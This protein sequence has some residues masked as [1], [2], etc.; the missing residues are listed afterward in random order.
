MA[1]WGAL[2]GAIIAVLVIVGFFLIW[3]TVSRWRERRKQSD[4]S[5][6]FPGKM[7]EKQLE[8]HIIENFAELFPGWQLYQSEA[9]KEASQP[10]GKPAAVRYRTPAGEIDILCVDNKGNLV[11]VELKADKAPDKTVTQVDRYIAF[12]KENLAKSEQRVWGLIIA[13]SYDNRLQHILK[14]R[15]GIRVWT[16]DWQFKFNKRPT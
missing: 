13:D 2:V 11:V 15:R 8:E 4:A 16:Y 12:A 10:A 7:S 14:R 3:D 1:F 9:L 6:A 5:S